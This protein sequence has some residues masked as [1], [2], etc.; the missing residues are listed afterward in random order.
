MIK[1]PCK[2]VWDRFGMHS[3]FSGGSRPTCAG[4]ERVN[5]PTK[6]KHVTEGTELPAALRMTEEVVRFGNC[7]SEAF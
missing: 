6:R 7:S 4:T 5:L 1:R 2:D 3:E